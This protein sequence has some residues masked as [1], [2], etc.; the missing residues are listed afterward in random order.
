MPILVPQSAPHALR[1]NVGTAVLCSVLLMQSSL[2]PA[3][4]ENPL[5]TSDQIFIERAV[6]K[7]LHSSAVE[8]QREGLRQ[9][10]LA[11][12]EA[13]TADG[14]ITL[15]QALDETTRSALQLAYLTAT[16]AQPRILWVSTPPHHWFSESFSGSRVG[17]D[18]PDNI[19]RQVSLEDKGRY[20]IRGKRHQPGPVQ[21]SFLLYGDGKL[22]SGA[23]TPAAGLLDRDIK[24]E[25]DGSYLITLDNQPANGRPNHISITESRSDLLIRNSLNDWPNQIPD[26]LEIK[27]LDTLQTASVPGDDVLTA[28]LAEAYKPAT[29]RVL[30]MGAAIRAAFPLNAA[31]VPAQRGGG[32]GFASGGRFKLETDEALLITVDPLGANYTGSQVTDPWKISRDPVEHQ[33]SLNNVQTRANPDGTFTYVIAAKDPGVAN[34]LD[35][36]GLQNGYFFLRWQALPQ[37][38]NPETVKNAV[39]EVKLVKISDLPDSLAKV[40]PEQRAN[41]LAGR[42]AAFLRRFAVQAE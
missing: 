42:K 7:S 4:A 25:A 27:R 21:S 6:E 28:S 31:R 38:P 11:D 32:W 18:N 37:E 16:S 13:S 24:T 19:Y 14:K 26:Q 33:S 10:F 12:P 41:E 36:I 40:T 22:L 9:Q 3:H 23:D 17:I 34:W 35:T 5:T 2:V 8:K 29:L 15:D 20:E 30:A 39:R 1:R